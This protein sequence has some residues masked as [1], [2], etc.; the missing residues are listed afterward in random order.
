VTPETD[1]ETT[2]RLVREEQAKN[3]KIMK[4]ILLGHL[5]INLIIII[6]IGN[7][8]VANLLYLVGIYNILGP[9]LVIMLI[10]F[11]GVPGAMLGFS[12]DLFQPQMTIMLDTEG[13]E[14]KRSRV[15][16]IGSRLLDMIVFIAFI[17]IGLLLLVI[18]RYF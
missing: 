15:E 1:Q 9:L 14:L 16:S 3:Q 8:G 5:V 12:G 11:G 17:A 7:S 2:D 4:F 18:S 13:D 6:L 10:S